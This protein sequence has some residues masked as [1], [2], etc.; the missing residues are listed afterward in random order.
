MLTT[1]PRLQCADR[2]IADWPD[3]ID[4]VH[5][6]ILLRDESGDGVATGTDARYGAICRHPDPASPPELRVE[7][8]F[9]SSST[10][11]S[12]AWWS[13]RASLRRWIS[14]CWRFSSPRLP[15]PFVAVTTATPRK[16]GDEPS[17]SRSLHV[18]L[19]AGRHHAPSRY[20]AFATA[21]AVFIGSLVLSLCFARPG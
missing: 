7:S 19:P 1:E 9:G 5:L 8:I 18:S 6:A 20:Y 2:H 16:P 10:A 14:S 11:T 12:A 13:H 15:A 17:E 4:D 21:V 3:L